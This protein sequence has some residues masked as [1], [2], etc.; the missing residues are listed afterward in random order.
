MSLRIR[1]QDGNAKVNPHTF[2]NMRQFLRFRESQN[3]SIVS[4]DWNAMVQ[5]STS[6]INCAVWIGEFAEM[7]LEKA[8]KI[9]PLITNMRFHAARFRRPTRSKQKEIY[10]HFTNLKHLNFVRNVNDENWESFMGCRY[11]INDPLCSD[12]SCCASTFCSEMCSII[13][14]NSQNTLES[15]KIDGHCF[16][17]YLPL[18]FLGKVFLKLQSF[19]WEIYPDTD[20]HCSDYG[21]VLELSMMQ[22]FFNQFSKMFP[23]LNPEG[24]LWWWLVSE[25]LDGCP[26]TEALGKWMKD[27]H[28]QHICYRGAC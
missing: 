3:L 15:L 25:M 20:L 23:N 13:F 2:Q 10:P 21:E 17:L 14:E 4:R 18:L 12:C 27:T 11:D 22:N 5:N 26:E 19:H 24:G 9:C 6:K 28:S 7:P 1:P 16:D 8:K